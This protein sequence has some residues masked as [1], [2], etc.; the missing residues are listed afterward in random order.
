VREP[1]GRHD[2]DR[3]VIPALL[4]ACPSFT[5]TWN[6]H[7]ADWAGDDAHERGVYTDVGVF[8]NHLVGLIEQEETREFPAVFDTVERLFRD[9]DD[10][11]RCV[12]KVGLLEDLG[13]IAANKHGWPFA[14][15]FR[16]WFGPAATSAWDEL[17]LE[18]G[19]SDSG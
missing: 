8:A 19:T 18:W 1:V 4:E 11:V 6:L 17:H 12:L 5:E 13:N 14:A 3:T 16:H 15:R 2:P 9:G 7:V 10:S